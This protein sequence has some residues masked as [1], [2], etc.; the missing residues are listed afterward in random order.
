MTAF[1]DFLLLLVVVLNIA[2]VATG[3]L[4]ACVRA[5]AIQGVALALLPIALWGGSFSAEAIHIAIMSGGT[6]AVKALIVPML[7]RRVIR[8]ADSRREVE[9]FISFHLSVLIATALVGIS[10]WM[11]GMLALPQPPPTPL[12]VP[13]AFATLFI[14]FLMLVSRRTA[15]SQVIGYVMLENG[16]FIFGQILVKDIPFAVEMGILLDLLVGVFVMGIAIR[17]ISR[18][19]DHIDTEQLSTLKD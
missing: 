15:I 18:E 14:G 1:A 17:H 2:I 6:L 3:R 5:T 11:A 4:A 19:F 12:L 9:P 8:R 16:I 13:I 7:L 10:F